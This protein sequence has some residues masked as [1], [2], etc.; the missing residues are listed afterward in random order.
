MGLYGASGMP[1]AL[2]P[3]QRGRAEPE[4]DPRVPSERSAPLV[5]SSPS[6]SL[7]RSP[8]SDAQAGARCLLLPSEL[9]RFPGCSPKPGGSIPSSLRSHS[10]APGR[11]H[12]V[13]SPGP[14]SARGRGERVWGHWGRRVPPR[15]PRGSYFTCCLQA[16]SWQEASARR[17]GSASACPR[18]RCS[19]V[20]SAVAVPLRPRRRHA[21]LRQPAS[22]ALP[23]CACKMYWRSLDL[24]LRGGKKEKKIKNNPE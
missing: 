8:P 6:V 19:A 16:A 3:L 14:L 18:A 10:G 11:S 1:T 17:G 23:V 9:R 4:R 24:G 12:V 22:R 20:P 13:A 7:C 21:V 2:A 15:P 5:T